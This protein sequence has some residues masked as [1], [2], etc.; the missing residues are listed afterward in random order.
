[1][2]QRFF[3]FWMVMLGSAVPVSALADC[4]TSNA[5]VENGIWA[6]VSLLDMREHVELSGVT[7]GTWT[8]GLVETQ[9]TESGTRKGETRYSKSIYPVHM[10]PGGNAQFNLMFT[11]H[12]MAPDATPGLNIRM[13]AMVTEGHGTGGM[14]ARGYVS[15]SF[16]NETYEVKLGDCTVQAFA[17]E[18]VLSVPDLGINSTREYHFLPDL[19]IA[20]M[21]RIKNQNTGEYLD[22]ETDYFSTDRPY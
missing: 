19:Q 16:G 2:F 6:T 14:P 18:R 4:P 13:G 10:E 8:A 11:E 7:G 21:S 1:M 17:M 22:V 3:T 15:F 12:L 5:D 9:Y 20:I